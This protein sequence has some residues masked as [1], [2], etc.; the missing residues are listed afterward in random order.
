MQK[1]ANRYFIPIDGQ[2]IEVS[3]EVYRAYYRPIWNTGITPKRTAS[4]AAPKLKFGSATAF[5][6]AARSTLP[7][8]RYLSTRPSAAR[9]TI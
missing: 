9:M 6:R 3:E 7:G 4:A 5:A 8:R 2:A 1:K